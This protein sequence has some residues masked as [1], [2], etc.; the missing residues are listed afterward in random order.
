MRKIN[1]QH[2]V[3][4][5]SNLAYQLDISEKREPQLRKFLQIWSHGHACVTFSQLLID[6]GGPW[7]LWRVTSMDRCAWT[8]RK[9]S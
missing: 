1:F 5:M 3:S 7:P 9:G 2:L 6:E 8:E 4:V